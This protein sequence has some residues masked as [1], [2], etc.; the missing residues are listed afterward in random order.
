[1][2]ERV[3]IFQIRPSRFKLMFLRPSFI[4]KKLHTGVRPAFCIAT[5]FVSRRFSQQAPVLSDH[6][7]G[8]ITAAGG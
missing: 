7:I 2:F 6:G 5:G 4:A 8:H 1:M 3:A